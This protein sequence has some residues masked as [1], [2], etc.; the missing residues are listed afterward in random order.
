MHYR[1]WETEGDPGEAKPR[2]QRGRRKPVLRGGGGYLARHIPGRGVIGIHRLVIEEH[3]G[4]RLLPDENVHH[5]NGD[6]A[7]N[8]LEN[9]ELWVKTQPAGQ[10][11]ADL[12][13]WAYDILDRYGTQSFTG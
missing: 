13:A 3:L 8:R 10:R 4:R 12:V 2:K 5:R 1:R 9:L 6:R 11:P 7:D